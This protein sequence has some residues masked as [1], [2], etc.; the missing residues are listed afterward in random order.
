MGDRL[1]GNLLLNAAKTCEIIGH[2][3]CGAWRLCRQGLPL[4]QEPDL[5]Q[6]ERIAFNESRLSKVWR[7]GR[8]VCENETGE[9]EYAADTAPDHM[10]VMDEIE[11]PVEVHLTKI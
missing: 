2:F 4:F 3:S 1:L 8:E 5:F 6:R 7:R 9:I 11:S 10:A